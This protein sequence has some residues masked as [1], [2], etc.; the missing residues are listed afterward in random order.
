MKFSWITSLRSLAVIALFPLAVG[1]GQKTATT[2]LGISCESDRDCKQGQA[3]VIT[4]VFLQETEE[5]EVTDKEAVSEEETAEVIE[6]A[7]DP[8][9]GET[10]PEV[11]S[12]QIPCR[13]DVDCPSGFNCVAGGEESATGV[14]LDEA[15]TSELDTL[16]D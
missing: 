4:P 2:E 1:C 13:A 7:P 12:C 10:A 5:D 3:C 6:P 8:A 14:C 15:R 16:D 11:K 9:T